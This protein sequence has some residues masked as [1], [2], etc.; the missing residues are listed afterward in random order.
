MKL[1]FEKIS[2]K[3]FM[4]VGAV[5]LVLEYTR[6]LNAIVAKPN[7]SSDTTNGQG[8][9][10]LGIDALVFALFGKSIRGLNLKEMVNNINQ[11]EC[12][13]TLWFS[14][15][16]VKWRIERGIAPDYL[17]II[18]EDKDEDEKPDEE[19]SAKKR[20]QSKINALLSIS[21]T[22]FI[23]SITLN[24]NYSKPF[25][26]LTAAEK[27]QV[28]EDVLNIVV[29]GKMF[30][31]TKKEYNSFKEDK[32]VFESELRSAK[33]LFADKKS[34]FEKLEQEKQQF[35]QTKKENIQKA[36]DEVVEY[37]NKLDKLNGKIPSTDFDA[38]KT[39]LNDAK[40]KINEKISETNNK[41]ENIKG[42]ISRKTNEIEELKSNPICHFCKTPIDSSEHTQKHIEKLNSEIAEKEVLL[43]KIEEGKQ[44]LK[45]K[46]AEI[47]SKITKADDAIEKIAKLQKIVDDLKNRISSGNKKIE[48]ETQKTFS[49]SA[50]VSQDDL[51]KLEA[52]VKQKETDYNE[53][54]EKMRYYDFIKDILGDQGIKKYIIKK[55]IPLLNKKTNE[56]LSL[57]KAKYTLAFDGDL[58]EKFKMRNR[59]D[60]TYNSFSAGQQKRID[61]AFMFALLDVAKQ[62]SSID[63]N[64]LILDEIIDS[65]ICSTGIMHL[66]NFLKIDFMKKYPDMAVYIISHKSE[67]SED[68]FNSIITVKM[69]NEFTKI[70]SIKKIDQIV[71]V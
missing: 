55:V 40:D 2:L 56:Y 52:K 12:E 45:T 29:Y 26:K 65:S 16:G 17:R 27:R 23:N 15:D 43:P 58:N 44:L 18:K 19:E 20:T 34:T 67:V 54:C 22:S 51:D 62:Q 61:L 9:S 66:I 69:D 13:V 30:E 3:N 36:S 46:L 5:P 60:R 7:L 53:V 6:G 41:Y 47:K 10:I 39:K 37:K 8:K 21:Y 33:E 14:V 1:I 28:L 49:I 59:E 68:N 48:E 71:Q 4:S 31:K 63:S 57:F 24:I 42:E 11:A 64:I 50:I 25:F 38:I 35:E 70:D 32:R